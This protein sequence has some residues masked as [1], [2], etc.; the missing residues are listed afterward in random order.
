MRKTLALLLAAVMLLG[1]SAC[2]G[3]AEPAPT[4]PAT[5]DPVEKMTEASTEELTT[6][7]TEPRVAPVDFE[8]VDP[9]TLPKPIPVEEQLQSEDTQTVTLGTLE[10]YEDLLWSLGFEEVRLE[11]THSVKANSEAYCEPI[12]L[13]YND[14]AFRFDFTYCMTDSA[15]TTEK[16]EA[17]CMYGTKSTALE[18]VS[19]VSDEAYT[20]IKMTIIDFSGMGASGAGEYVPSQG[21]DLSGVDW[22]SVINNGEAKQDTSKTTPNYEEEFM[23]FLENDDQNRFVYVKAVYYPVTG[24]LYNYMCDPNS[25]GQETTN[26]S[27]TPGGGYLGESAGTTNVGLL[28]REMCFHYLFPAEDAAE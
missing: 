18:N 5:T 15:G 7:P 2:G 6:A 27:I 16:E 20:K 8:A 1:L 12:S 11:G 10:E 25:A 14:Q 19:A 28:A 23:S 9:A 3:S 17:W 26:I 21:G 13:T 4:A 22:S 24:N